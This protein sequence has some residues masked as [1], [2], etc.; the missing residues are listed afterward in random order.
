[1]LQRI[2]A[3]EFLPSSNLCPRGR[4]TRGLASPHSPL[5]RSCDRA[6]SQWRRSRAEHRLEI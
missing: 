1:M 2:A 6:L 4:R 5:P 3:L